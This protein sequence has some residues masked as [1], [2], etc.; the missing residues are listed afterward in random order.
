[1]TDRWKKSKIESGEGGMLFWG[2]LSLIFATAACYFYWQ[3]NQNE[4]IARAL[5]DQEVLLK[6]ENQRLRSEVDKLQSGITQADSLLKTREER[7]K[8]REHSLAAAE[9]EKERLTQEKQQRETA[10]K[11]LAEKKKLLADQIRKSKELAEVTVEE[12]NGEPII[13]IPNRLLFTTGEVSLK[14]EGKQLV[15]KMGQL[16][17]E[18]PDQ[19]IHVIG[20]TDS[21]PITST[22][23]QKYPTNRDL[24]LARAT[25]VVDQLQEAGIPAAR[26]IVRGFGESQPVASN[27]TREGKTKNRRIEI[28]LY[29]IKDAS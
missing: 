12:K 19:E 8:E 18:L 9:Q 7:L 1:M 2:A 22:M 5:R 15:T 16:L 10:K 28:N 23:A 21:D 27:S 6:S 13:V 24:S 20:H 14:P 25:L 4:K 17:G 11:T 3:N 29:P 26:L